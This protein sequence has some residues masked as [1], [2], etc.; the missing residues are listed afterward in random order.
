MWCL[1]TLKKLNEARE[2]VLRK[3]AEEEAEEVRAEEATRL[4][5][6]K[7]DLMLEQA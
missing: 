3:H 6:I 4:H 7:A 5:Q 1:E 2:R